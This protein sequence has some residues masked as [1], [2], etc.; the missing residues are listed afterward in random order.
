MPSFAHKRLLETIL[1]QDALP[2]DPTE[3]SQWVGAPAHLKFL[4]ENALADE[5]VIYGSGP[6]TFIHTIA[7]TD[8]ALAAASEG[9]LLAWSS[10]PYTSI[11]SY[12]SGGGRKDM[13]IER[14]HRD[15]GSKT[16]EQG[17]DL[18]FGRTFEGWSGA[19]KL[20]FEAH[21]EYTHL[22]GIHWRPEEHA[23]CRFDDNGDL[24]HVISITAR[25]NGDDA[26]VVSF[27][28]DELEEYLTI[29]Q[30]SLVRMFDFTLLK[31][32]EFTSWPDIPEE[33]YHEATDFFYRQRHCGNC[34][35]TRGVQILRPRRT[36]A[37]VFQDVTDSWR[38]E[39]DK[40]YVEFLA[41]DWRNK[42]LAKISTD[43]AATT[44]YFEAHNNEKPFELSPAFF[45]PE[46][47]SKYKTDR[48]KYTIKDREI[49][50]RAAWHLRGYDVN[51]AGQIH[52]YIC[53]LRSLPYS[54]QLHWLSY[55]VEPK[56]GI[57]ARAFTNDFKGEFVT[58]THPREEIMAIAR[59]WQDRG[60]DWWT[61][62]DPD[63][64]DRANVPLTSSKDEW[65]DAVMDISKIVVE[66]FQ[67]T[68]LRAHLDRLGVAYEQEGT[69]GLLEKAL[70][71]GR[72]QDDF[73][74]LPGM[75]EAQRIRS[76]VKGH[77]GGSAADQITRAALTEH[78]TFKDHFTHLCGRIAAEM[79]AIGL[80]FEEGAS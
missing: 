57:S 45:R 10:N 43:P 13:W 38:G 14:G 30:S 69:I 37:Q 47:L 7:V 64:L 25:D 36:Q 20:Y 28:W 58:Y 29:S 42:R 17:M 61:L 48:E 46:V 18:I 11:A 72:P 12:V 32:D 74:P 9:D 50:C 78:G 51:E 33:I 73:F 49:S 22:A 68:A 16:L 21:Q 8:D 31:R 79:E 75:R 26:A 63:L 35:Y 40:Q 71:Y 80:H 52:A 41:Q 60:F 55:N 65:S 77:V 54:E 76:K 34:A 56:S 44:N 67:T 62:R 6:Y 19:D 59:R 66:G 70:N 5:V 4:R 1:K 27:T 39:R 53:D 24:R 15:H 2:S 23:Y 3:F